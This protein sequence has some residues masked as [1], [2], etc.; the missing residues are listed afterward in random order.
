VVQAFNCCFQ[1]FN[2]NMNFKFEFT[3]FHLF[4]LLNV[5]FGGCIMIT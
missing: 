4:Q 5:N 3:F 1:I 2:E